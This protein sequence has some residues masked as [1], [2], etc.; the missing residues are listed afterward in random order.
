[1]GLQ[2]SGNTRDWW[3]ERRNGETAVS[4][5]NWHRG[6]VGWTH[7]AWKINAKCSSKHGSC[8]NHKYNSAWHS[9]LQCCLAALMHREMADGGCQGGV[10]VGSC[11]GKYSW[12]FGEHMRNFW[13][14]S[15]CNFKSTD[16]L[17]DK[18]WACAGISCQAWHTSQV[19]F[20]G[21]M[22]WIVRCHHKLPLLLT[23][24]CRQEILA[25]CLCRE[26]K[27]WMACWSEVWGKAIPRR[28]GS[29]ACWKAGCNKHFEHW[30]QFQYLAWLSWTELSPA[31]LC[32]LDLCLSWYGQVAWLPRC[33]FVF[34]TV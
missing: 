21:K 2:H 3:R 34:N 4:P 13:V 11:A 25:L 19:T 22:G 28:A 16:S 14:S 8:K 18:M 6:C 17:W 32:C 31:Q 10:F 26:E 24:E 20:R 5:L 30:L 23:W 33:A 15:V 7:T 12:F 9:S 29:K 27:G 1:M